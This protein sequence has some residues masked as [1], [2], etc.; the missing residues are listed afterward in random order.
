MTRVGLLVFI[1]VVFSFGGHNAALLAADQPL[2]S[3]KVTA[4]V[5]PGYH[6]DYPGWTSDKGRVIILGQYNL[7]LGLQAYY[8][9][10]GEWPGSWH[11]VVSE[12]LCQSGLV[13]YQLE[14][15][16]PDDA[17]LDFFG[18]LVYDPAPNKKT[19]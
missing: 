3:E 5:H 16:D 4:T 6:A 18:D 1:L 9:V 2:V 7:A 8:R 17:Q 10:F 14:V 12:G 15:I 19:A 13:G 11:D